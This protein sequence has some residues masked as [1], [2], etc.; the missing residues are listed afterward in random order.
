MTKTQPCPT[1]QGK[2]VIEATF[3]TSSEWHNVE[4]DEGTITTPEAICPTCG[5]TGIEELPE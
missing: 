3:E 4:G 2:K 5:G 1:C